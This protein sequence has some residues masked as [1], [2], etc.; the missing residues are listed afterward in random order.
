MSL[1]ALADLPFWY[2]DV[3]YVAVRY[4]GGVPRGELNQGANCQLWSYEV[5]GH[6]GFAVPD[7]R[8]DEL[9]HDIVATHRRD[10][11]RL[12]PRRAAADHDDSLRRACGA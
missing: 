2:W 4:P 8:S 1:G 10:L 5:L 3:P 12:H 7:F 6:F 11:C 9:W